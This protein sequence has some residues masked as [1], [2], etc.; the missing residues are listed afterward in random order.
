MPTT[1]GHTVPASSGRRAPPSIQSTIPDSDDFEEQPDSD[2]DFGESQVSTAV[3]AEALTHEHPGRYEIRREFGR[4][5]MSVVY[6]AFDSHIGREVAFKQLLKKVLEQAEQMGTQGKAILSRFMREARITGQLEHPSIVPVYEVGRR[7]DGSL[8]Y[9]QK[10]IRGRTMTKALK[11]TKNL[12]ERLK[13]LSHFVDLCQAIGYAHQR[14]VVHRDIKPDNVM[15]GEFGETV[16]LDWGIARVVSEGDAAEREVL[17]EN[18]DETQE[19]DVIGTPAYMSPEQAFGRQ[20]QIDSQSDVWSLGA[21]LY[22]L[23]TG[24]P[25]FSGK[26]PVAIIMKVQKDP[27]VPIKSICPEAP[28][29]LAAVAERALQRDKKQRYKTGRQLATEIEAFQ[30]GARVSAYEYSSWTLVKRFVKR[31]KTISIVSLVAILAIC[32]ALVR[33]YFENLKARHNLSQ[34]LLEKS[35]AAGRNLNW[36][37]ATS[38]A[39]AARVEE[40]SAEARFRAV[41]RGPREIEPVYRL[42]MAA[43]VDA[44][45]MA[46]DGK[47]LAAALADKTIRLLDA[48]SGRELAKCEG[49][50]GTITALTFSPDG[51]LLASAAS[52]RTVRAWSLTSGC[53]AAGREATLGVVQNLAFSPNSAALALGEA[54]MVHLFEMPGLKDAGRLSGHEGIIVS[55]AFSPDGSR[56]ASSDTFG[57]V[58]T[59]G[60]LPSRPSG[61]V[62]A[63]SVVL[64]GGGHQAINRVGYSPN[65]KILASGSDDETVRFFDAERPDVQ[66]RR[67]NPRQGEIATLTLS[68]SNILA[69]L[70]K[71]SSAV[72]FDFETMAPV[73]RLPGDDATHS[74]SFSPDG[75]LFVTANHDGRLRLWRI[76]QGTAVVGLST[77]NDVV[78]NARDKNGRPV[79][80]TQTTAVASAASGRKV[81]SADSSGKLQLWDVP[82]KQLSWE[83]SGLAPP[84]GALGF[85]PDGRFIAVASKESE[86][87][88]LTASDGSRAFTLEGHQGAVTALDFSPDGKIIASGGADGTVRLWDM[89]SKKQKQSLQAGAAVTALALSND[90]KRLAA[91]TEDGA[92]RIWDPRS[93]KLVKKVDGGGEAVLALA[94]SPHRSLLVSGGVDQ[95]IRVFHADAGSLR[96]V[97]TGHGGRIF[98][99]SF[100][101]DGETLASSSRDG[102]IRLWDVRTGRTM[103]R[104]ERPPEARAAVFTPDGGW[105]VSAGERPSVQFVELDDKKTLLTPDKELARRLKKYKLRFD[106]I[107]LSDDVDALV[108]NAKRK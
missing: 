77:S 65:G 56:L 44:V 47:H 20:G 80:P 96:S 100:A 26:N 74:A 98:S 8:Y 36:L 9:T 101:P 60:P 108:P 13:L 32:G 10:L 42:Q 78:T 76:L 38:Y 86:V 11:E 85:S 68:S 69:S 12:P 55:V 72:L 27:I 97:W 29:E 87:L 84:I 37:L 1:P 91:G 83:I 16:V 64:R 35:D 106:G 51:N 71:D 99:L 5:G 34:A 94:F 54:G 93:G 21:V 61:R 41:Q 52:D 19:G 92:V 73:A 4:G 57:S 95:V 14:G 43:G 50:D 88:V 67:L 90:D 2:A 103:A 45:A 17:V 25:P 104:L 33:T 53:E 63:D 15:V 79:R 6:L 30:S 81:A 31:N 75:K 58:R 82:T 89:G 62:R 3:E 22:E 46:A 39:A 59:W 23:L 66:L 70:G 102:T 7:E 105:L 28:P 40:D 18:N 48:T 107:S 49:H 24:Q